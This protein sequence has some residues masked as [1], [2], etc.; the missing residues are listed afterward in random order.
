MADGGFVVAYTSYVYSSDQNGDGLPDGG[1]NTQEIRLQRYSNTAPV[2]TDVFVSGAED[3]SIVLTD[4]LFIS[5]FNDP[6]G[7]NLAAIKITTLPAE[8]TLRL[9]GVDL[10]AGQEISLADLQAGKLTYQGNANY[11]GLDQFAWTGSDGVAF[12]GTR[13]T[14]TSTSPTSMTPRPSKPAPTTPPPKATS[15]PTP[16]PSATPTR[17]PTRS[18]NWG[19]GSPNSV[20]NTSAD[21]FNIGHT[22]AD[23]GVYNVTVT[24]NDQQGQANSVQVDGF[25]VT[26]SNVAPDLNLFGDA[27]VVQNEVHP[28]PRRHHRAGRRHPLR[29]PHR[30]GRR[31]P[32]PGRAAR[33][34]ARQPAAHPRLRHQRRRTINVSLADE[35]GSYTNV[36]TK[37]VTVSAPAEVLTS[38]PAPT[39]R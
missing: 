29:I 15:S 26:V 27:T 36:A 16:S 33:R 21:L 23:D 28:H 37:A 25:Q 34:P 6:E 2:L 38:M 8:G 5:G 3:S 30:L 19:D 13:F 17:T 22:Y 9:D 31:Q 35:D 4:A 7:Q 10:I 39:A 24:A 1:N 20:Y 18:P 12:A 11:F 14:P 32:H